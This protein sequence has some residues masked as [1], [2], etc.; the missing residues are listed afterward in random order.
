MAVFSIARVNQTRESAFSDGWAV[1]RH[2][3]GQEDQFA[4]RLF[5]TSKEAQAECDRLTEEEAKKNA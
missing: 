2:E 1:I 4:S 5:F 3:S